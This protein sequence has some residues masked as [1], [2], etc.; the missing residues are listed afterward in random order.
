MINP[1]ESHIGFVTFGILVVISLFTSPI[2]TIMV[3]LF[4]IAWAY[5]VYR[6]NS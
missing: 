1:A 3:M 6:S 2:M 4:L 5:A